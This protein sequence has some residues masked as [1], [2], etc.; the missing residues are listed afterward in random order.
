MLTGALAGLMWSKI[1][2]DK[3]VKISFLE[4]SKYGLI[5]ML[6]ATIVASLSLSM[7]LL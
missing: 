4:F 5:T 6:P 2:S 1:L 3:G 7:I